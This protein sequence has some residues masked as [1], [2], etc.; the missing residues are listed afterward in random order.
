M[1]SLHDIK[2][3]VS[4]GESETLE[5]KKSTAEQEKACHTL[6]AMANR[7]GGKVI[8]G[9]TP[10][11]KIVGQTIG[12]QTLER[13]A[14]EFKHF[15]PPVFPT[16]DRIPLEGS[17]EIIVVSMS[18]ATKI[19]CNFKGKTYKRIGNTTSSMPQ[20]EYQRL[21]VEEMHTHQRWENISA[22]DWALSMLDD[23][24]IILTLEESIRRG[25]IEDPQTRD[26]TEILRGFGL[27]NRNGELLHAAI[28]LFAKEDA[29]LPDFPQLKLRLAKFRGIDK[30]EFLDN[31]QFTGNAFILLR[32]AE[33]FLIDNLPISG[34]IIP[35]IIERVDDPLYPLAALRE[36]LANAF[37]HRDYGI[38]GGS[39]GIAIYDDRLE[40]TSSGGLHFGLSVE[41]LY[42]PHESLPWNPLIAQVFYRRGIIESWGRGTLKIIE[43]TQTAGLVSPEIKA[44]GGGMVSVCFQPNHYIAPR[45]IGHDLNERQHTILHILG[46]AQ[47][48]NGMQLYKIAELCTED[49]RTIRFDL[50]FLK[51]L[52]CVETNGHGLGAKWF[53]VVSRKK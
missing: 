48:S 51:Q 53:L 34:K 45:H 29:I 7:N 25:R 49:K 22:P 43:L 37:C 42:K 46:E 44:D 12:S 52:G 10:Q 14:Q 26:I 39:V 47:A 24:E 27:I 30:T 9:I 36:A 50:Q 28:V 15:D 32:R 8:F 38:V 2:S 23:R 5:F 4:L 21:M 11:G 13:L 18:H 1:F 40:I 19:L 3:W 17:K 35:G 31:K 16:I 20:A 6:C 41:D 33:R